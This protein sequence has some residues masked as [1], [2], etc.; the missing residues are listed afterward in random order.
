MGVPLVVRVGTPVPDMSSP[1]VKLRRGRWGWEVLLG[2]L[3]FSRSSKLE[4]AA[5]DALL[6]AEAYSADQVELGEGVPV[7]ALERGAAFRNRWHIR[8]H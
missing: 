3:L 5:V 7:D 1:T 4:W 6:L 2:D 8:P